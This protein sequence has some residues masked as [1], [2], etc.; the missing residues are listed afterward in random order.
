[1]TYQSAV[2]RIAFLTP[3]VALVHATWE[4]PGFRLPTGEDARDFKGII[5]MVM[6]RRG[7]TWLIRAVQNT[8]TA[9]APPGTLS[10]ASAAG[11]Q[12]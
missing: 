5:T 3:E 7:G 4:W 10:Q 12:P 2:A 11:G 9:G 8:V 6:V 1:M